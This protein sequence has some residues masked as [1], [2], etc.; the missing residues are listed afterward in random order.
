M[1]LLPKVEAIW[2]VGRKRLIIPTL[3]YTRRINVFVTLFWPSK[4]IIWNVFRRRRNIEFRQHLSHVLAYARRHKLKK[5]VMFVDHAPYH[6]TGEV[7]KFR[8]K[9]RD[10]L[11]MKFLGKKDPNSNPTECL[12]NKRLNSAISVNR[13]HASIDELTH[14]TREFLG[15][16]NNIYAT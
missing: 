13:C 12:V 3:G 1:E 6:K 4:K 11:R 14:A 15:R 2:R 5:I 10:V 16:Y 9:H 7:K 8:R